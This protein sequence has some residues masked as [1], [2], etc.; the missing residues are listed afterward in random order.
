MGARMTR[1]GKLFDTKSIKTPYVRAG[2]VYMQPLDGSTDAQYHEW[3]GKSCIWVCFVPEGRDS[4]SF[5]SH[6]CRGGTFHHSSLSKG[7]KVV[8]A[9][10][11]IVED[12]KLKKISA[13]SGRYQPTM[14]YLHNAVL[15]MAVARQPDTTIFLRHRPVGGTGHTRTQ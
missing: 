11:W 7:G 10:E 14:D 8:A 9:G 1:D 4:V 5:Y 15:H 3:G 12:G 6:V 2:E 13:N